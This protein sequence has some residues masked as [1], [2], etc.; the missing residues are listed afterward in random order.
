MSYYLNSITQRQELMLSLVVCKDLLSRCD[1]EECAL[2]LLERQMLLTSITKV[3]N[4]LRRTSTD[5]SARAAECETST[6]DPTTN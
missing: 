5:S 6:G 2:T 4:A 1:L 3:L